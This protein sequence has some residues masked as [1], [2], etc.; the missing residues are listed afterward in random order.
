MWARSEDVYKYTHSFTTHSFVI[1]TRDISQRWRFSFFLGGGG[2][3]LILH[4]PHSYRR[5]IRSVRR[6]RAVGRYDAYAINATG[7]GC[8]G[9]LKRAVAYSR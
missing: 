5:S 9:K 2:P 3:L 7:A 4:L 1:Q 6:H 8:E